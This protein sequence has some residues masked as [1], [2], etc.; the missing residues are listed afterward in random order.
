MFSPES[1]SETNIA[2]LSILW[3]RNVGT[4]VLM[5]ICNTLVI[6]KLRKSRQ[7]VAGSTSSTQEAKK[8]AREARL[9]IQ[10]LVI[11]LMYVM[12]L[13][14]FRIL[15]FL[16]GSSSREAY[17]VLSLLASVN[18]SVNPVIYLGKLETR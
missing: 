2:D 4:T 18:S 6:L 10:F 17:V 8:K 7:A 15:P 3:P 5:V 11:A 14:M 16:I 1:A 9:T 13:A 12:V